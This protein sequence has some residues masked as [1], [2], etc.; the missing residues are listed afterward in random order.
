MPHR[1][2]PDHKKRH[3]VHVTL[4]AVRRLPSLRRQIIFAAMRG[5][6][7]NTK[8]AWVRV[9]HFSVQPDHVHLLVEA[10][11]KVCLSRGMAGLMVRMAR[12]VNRALGR[13]GRVWSDRFHARALRTP[14]ET[15]H[16]LVYVLMN[17]RKH[18]PE[19]KGIDPCSSGLWF[20][21][22]RIPPSSGPPETRTPWS[23]PTTSAN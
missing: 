1:A 16:G 6:I 19:A 11:D 15:R 14:R 17:W 3:P 8:L 5:T 2:R 4:R 7:A 20:E 21:G 10:D 18:V 12:W 22:W 23:M 13:R 9:V